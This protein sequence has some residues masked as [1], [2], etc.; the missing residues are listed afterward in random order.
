[1][2]DDELSKKTLRE[3]LE[4]TRN[5]PIRNGGISIFFEKLVQEIEYLE[6]MIG[7]IHKHITKKE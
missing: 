3:V 6:K 4:Y 7:G 5:I 1:M 2:N